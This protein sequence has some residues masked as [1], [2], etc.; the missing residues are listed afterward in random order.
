MVRKIGKYEVLERI[1]RGGMG[2][3]FRARDPFLD[4]IV[5]LKV[6]AN[7]IDVTE[8]IRARF[9]REAQAC[10]RL[11]HKNIVTIYDMGEEEGQLYIVMEFLEGHELRQLIAARQSLLVEDKLA[12]MIQVCEGLHYAHQQGII[13]RDVK[14]GNIFVLRNGLVKILD[15]GLAHVASETN[16]TRTGLVV[17]TLRYISPEQV[18]GRADHRSD[19]FSVGAVFY[20]LLTLRP[21]FAGPDPMQILEQLRSEEPPT[22]NTVD[23]TI[24]ADLSVIIERA[25]RKD[26]GQRFADL[27]EMRGQLEGVQRRFGEEAQRLRGEVDVKLRRIRELETTLATH[28]GAVSDATSPIAVDGQARVATLEALNQSLAR[29]VERLQALLEKAEALK[30]GYER[31]R[32]LIQAGEYDE[33]V[34]TLEGVT[35]Q[36]P[37]HEPAAAALAEARRHAEEARRRAEVQRRLDEGAAAFGRGS[38][39]EC[40]ESIK[41]LDELAA[42][43]GL[44][45]EVIE[46]RGSA[47]AALT[48]QQEELRRQRTRAEEAATLTSE[49]RALAEEV[50]AF[51]RAEARWLAA[52]AKAGEAGTAFDQ[53]AYERAAA[54]YDEATALYHRAEEEAREAVR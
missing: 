1:G 42:A 30:P 44:A 50:E 26:P 43:A 10:A 9:F 15:F 5:A 31:G 3:V 23:P 49:G 54:A 47:T 27:A 39:A 34:T 12:V 20:E 38:F 22:P 52:E 36:L 45:R 41:G 2:M 29:R 51:R 32:A 21:A 48:V 33:A 7:D 46:L 13:H 4:R 18:R 19:I 11:N 6:I 14:P 17:G 37:E 24:P 35:G 28:L 53:E 40:L 8:E 16:L 25:L